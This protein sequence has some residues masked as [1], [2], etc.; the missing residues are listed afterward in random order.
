CVDVIV[1]VVLAE[2]GVTAPEL[3]YDDYRDVDVHGKIVMLISGAPKR[4]PNDQRAYYSSGEVKRKNAAAHGAIGILALSSITDEV[5][6]P[7]EKRVQQ[8]GI[9]PMTILDGSGKPA[10]VVEELSLLASLSR[11]TAATLFAGTPATIDAVLAE[12]EKGVGTSLP[13]GKVA[14]AHTVSHFREVKSQNV[15]GTLKGNDEYVVVSAH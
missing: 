1:P 8:S 12:A 13:L 11:A 9:T 10:D 3:K 4:F 6:N 14:S 7:F 5:R 15:V 2:C